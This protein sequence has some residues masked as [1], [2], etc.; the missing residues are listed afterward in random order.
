MPDETPFRIAV[1]FII[2]TALCVSGFFRRRA[3][4]TGEKISSREEGLFILVV[5]RL[6]GL[7]MSTSVLAYVIHPPA[8]DWAAV[9]LPRRLR[10]LAMA[11]SLA[12]APLLGWTLSALGRNITS[13]VVVRREH[14]LV[15]TGPYRWVRHPLY[16]FGAITWLSV[17][18]MAANAFMVAI[19]LVGAVGLLL[20][21]PKEEAHLIE[22]FGDEYREYA[23]R[24]GRYLPRIFP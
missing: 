9:A 1:A 22:R 8:M 6:S 21:T 5:L 2:V 15:T 13:T 10:Y 17:S 20:R 16:T 4:Q 7:L 18:V 23:K 14:S 12:V 24:T 3:A 19:M 11:V